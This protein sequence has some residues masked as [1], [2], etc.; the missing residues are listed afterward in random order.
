MKKRILHSAV[1]TVF[2]IAT[3]TSSAQSWSILGNAGT[4]TN[5]NFLGTTN[6]KGLVFRTNNLE[7]M[8]IGPN[9]K[10]GIGITTPQAALNIVSSDVVSLSTPGHLMLG[11]VTQNNM[12]LDYNVIQARSN[13][14][15]ST[16]F[17]NYYGGA[18]W[19]GNRSGSAIPAV[20]AATSGSVGLGGSTTQLGFA[21]TI[22]PFSTGG[23]IYINDPGVGNLGLG[24]KSGNT[25]EGFRMNISSTTNP[26]AAIRGHTTGN[27]FGV[28]AEA[29]GPSGFGAEAYSSQ[30]YG[31][32]AGTGDVTTYAAYF[33]G[34]VFCSGSYFGSDENLKKN[35][36]DFSSGMSI[37]NQLH[38]KHYEYR[39]D[40][41]YKLMNMPIGEHY[42]LV[43]QDVEKI[44]PNLVKETKFYASKA[45][46]SESENLKNSPDINFKALNYTELIPIMIKGMQEQQ[47]TIQQ[48]QKQIDQQQ[49]QINDLKQML[50]TS[51]ASNQNSSTALS[52]AWL[53]QNTP[54]PFN[55]NTIIH[56][57]VPSS[58]K[59]AQLIV[60]S[61]D[62][63]QVKS[64]T[65]SNGTND[66]NI[67]AGTL[68][69]GQYTYSLLI[70]GKSIDNKK[71][72]LTK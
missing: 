47:S 62:G 60:Y 59:Q 65:L 27:G 50:Q 34:D 38:P 2:T 42:G 10:I 14:A 37:I 12:A 15:G 67:A 63:R 40:G 11:N 39:Q 70:D 68:A 28:L 53:Q 30:S 72:I 58:V 13:G 36:Q 17:L 54:N 55:Q 49:Q 18:T 32:W 3:L 56:C 5:T 29:T 31:L 48:Q 51:L 24:T 52:N 66:V 19:I 23:A 46:P 16:L 71:M 7:R 4:N 26:N 20:Y 33:S 9:G 57:F 1:V 61:L 69:S 43:A 21:V 44:L 64:F 22:N 25:G 41:N 45:V 6:S 8:R 35:I